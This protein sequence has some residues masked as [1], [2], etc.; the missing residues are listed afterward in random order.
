MV[1]DADIAQSRFGYGRSGYV[2]GPKSV[3]EMMALLRGP[4]LAAQ[5]F[6]I[7]DIAEVRTRVRV[8]VEQRQAFRKSEAGSEARDIL[9]KTYNGGRKHARSERAGWLA[10][11]LARRVWTGDALRERLTAFWADHFAAPGKIFVYRYLAPAHVNTAIRPFVAGKFEDML[12]A[13][14]TSPQMMHYLDQVGSVG[15]NSDFANMDDRAYKG[16][17]ENLAREIL[18]LHTL[19][20]GGAYTQTDVTQLAKLL[21]GLTARIGQETKYFS[22]RAEPGSETILGKEY[23]TRRSRMSDIHEVL[24]DLAR[25]PDT[26]QHIATKLA[27]HFVSDT[28]DPDLVGVLTEAY[29]ETDGDLGVVTEALLRHP[30]AWVPVG[31]GAGNFKQPELFVSTALRALAVPKQWFEAANDKSV[32]RLFERPLRKMGQPW[33]R[34]LGPDGFE[35]GDAHWLSAQGM[36]ARLQWT[37]GAPA[38]LVSELPDPREFVEEVLGPDAPAAVRFAAK[39]A[40]N[41][42]EG[43]AMVLMSPAFQRV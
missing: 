26:A 41:R 33:R 21:T 17:N 3:E 16:L 25:H 8:L 2:L 14:V 31:Q 7:D 18:E 40:E 19:G 32:T 24:R 15:P 13:A 38:Q 43:L 4:D 22:K 28:P 6:P 9:K 34:P 20:V 23:Q 42:R 27:V 10:A 29:L 5:D 11:D 39:A 37:L 30:A 36:G 35:E 1:F 12:I